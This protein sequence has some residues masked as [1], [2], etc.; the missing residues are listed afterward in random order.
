MKNLL[1]SMPITIIS[2]VIISVI[3]MNCYYV[4][5]NRNDKAKERHKNEKIYTICNITILTTINISI[6]IMLSLYT[7]YR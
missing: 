6:I 3:V 4:Y 1:I 2:T 5:T 7:Q